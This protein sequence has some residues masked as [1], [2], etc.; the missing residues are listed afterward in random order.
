MRVTA[1]GKLAKTILST[2]ACAVSNTALAVA[3]ALPA[4]ALTWLFTIGCSQ[5]V[6]VLGV[7]MLV[8]DLKA[9][10]YD[11]DHNAQE[12]ER[13]T[14]EQIKAKMLT[15]NDDRQCYRSHRLHCS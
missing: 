14:T 11:N 15:K 1:I 6:K 7:D 9:L 8:P 13:N 10:S 3:L 4:P 5:M 12:N 2:N